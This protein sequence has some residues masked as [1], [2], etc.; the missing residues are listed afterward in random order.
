MQGIA[1]LAGD[2]GPLYHGAL[3]CTPNQEYTVGIALASF[4]RNYSTQ[5]LS[6]W[7]WAAVIKMVL[8][9]H[10]VTVWQEEIVSRIYGLPFDL[11]GDLTQILQALSGGAIRAS[12][13]TARIFSTVDA[14]PR[15]IINDLLDDKPLIVLLRAANLTGGHA[16]AMTG[17]RL[18]FDEFGQPI[19]LSAILYDPSPFAQA[20][21]E[22]PWPM[23]I[24]RLDYLLR[25]A[26]VNQPVLRSW[27]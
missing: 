26:V 25:V 24:R 19:P 7:C 22:M 8:N 1:V 9:Y 10:G 14:L 2:Y 20:I 4:D 11:P 13:Q 3:P 21:Q 16:Y 23:F 27:H 17:L 18:R 12:G 5:I 15:D 6:K